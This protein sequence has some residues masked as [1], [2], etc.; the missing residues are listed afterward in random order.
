MSYSY[1]QFLSLYHVVLAVPIEGFVRVFETDR[2]AGR[3]TNQQRAAPYK[4]AG[5][6]G[7]PWRDITA[8]RV[9][10]QGCSTLITALCN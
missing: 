3:G 9:F 6:G 2:L 10:H 1:A 4:L 8:Q 7:N 5:I